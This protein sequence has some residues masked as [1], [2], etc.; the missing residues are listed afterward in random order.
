MSGEERGDGVRILAGALHAQ[1]ERLHRTQQHPRRI[2][3]ELRADCATQQPDRQDMRAVPGYAAGHQ[4]SVVEAS[5]E[6]RQD[7]DCMRAIL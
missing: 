6:G 1:L 3:I 7:G 5:D 4:V 2:G